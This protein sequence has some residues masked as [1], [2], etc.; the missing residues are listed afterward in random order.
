M[1]SM[2]A[3]SSRLE[4]LYLPKNSVTILLML[5]ESKNV[6]KLI[7]PEDMIT[8]AICPPPPTTSTPQKLSQILNSG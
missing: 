4:L 1:T 5:L 6:I 3:S 8:T 7:D 2:V